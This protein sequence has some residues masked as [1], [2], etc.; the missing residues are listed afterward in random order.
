MM[1]K[2]IS[3][4]FAAL[5]M[6]LSVSCAKSS[7]DEETSGKKADSTKTEYT[8]EEGKA[9][10]DMQRFVDN[11]IALSEDY[12]EELFD[13]TVDLYISNGKNPL[14]AN[15]SKEIQQEMQK[16]VG[17]LLEKENYQLTLVKVVDAAQKKMAREAEAES[18][19][20]DS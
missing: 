13:E 11:I 3:A 4:L 19:T 9:I 7:S 10:A 1:I 5:C 14:L 15:P 12:S 18:D 8:S 6:V 16:R 17:S 20:S 2:K